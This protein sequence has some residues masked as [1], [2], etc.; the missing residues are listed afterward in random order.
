LCRLGV[1]EPP[2]QQRAAA[3]K[4]LVTAVEA[5]A[6]AVAHVAE[7][8]GPDASVINGYS[9]QFVH[10]LKAAHTTLRDEIQRSCEPRPLGHMAT[11]DGRDR[12]ELAALRA[13]LIQ[14]HLTDALRRISMRS[15]SHS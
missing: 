15:P 1:M 4:D 3:T 13:G 10:A 12:L 5:V 11:G 9:E 14:S 6:A 2:L 7:G 8:A